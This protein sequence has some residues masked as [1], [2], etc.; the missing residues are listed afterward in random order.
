MWPGGTRRPF[1][2]KSGWAN[3]LQRTLKLAHLLVD[4]VVS[5]NA[6]HDARKRA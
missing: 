2:S 3:V 1:S 6:S 5:Q 4:R